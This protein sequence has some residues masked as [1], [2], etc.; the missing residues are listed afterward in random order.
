[1]S[2]VKRLMEEKA[3]I[4]ADAFSSEL[5]G[6]LWTLFMNILTVVPPEQLPDIFDGVIEPGR[7]KEALGP[8]LPKPKR[9]RS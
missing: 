2:A 6:D 7:L 3:G 4:L 8:L 1:M 9:S 5:Q